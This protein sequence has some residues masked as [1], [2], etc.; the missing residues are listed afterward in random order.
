MP[1]DTTAEVAAVNA[2]ASEAALV[3]AGT[4]GYDFVATVVAAA[5]YV[6]VALAANGTAAALVLVPCFQHSL[7]VSVTNICSKSSNYTISSTKLQ[8]Y[9]QQLQLQ[10]Q[11]HLPFQL[12]LYQ[13]ALE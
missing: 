5:D 3:A 4:A 10:R 13:Q 1:G 11:P 9:Q 2:A 8:L 6:V 12:Q 7:V